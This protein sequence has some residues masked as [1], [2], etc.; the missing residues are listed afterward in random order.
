[1]YDEVVGIQGGLVR[2][3]GKP[4]T[5][6]AKQEQAARAPAEVP[7][8]ALPPLCVAHQFVHRPRVPAGQDRRGTYV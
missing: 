1:M 5:V 8:L 7:G 6:L 4:G 2:V 3:D